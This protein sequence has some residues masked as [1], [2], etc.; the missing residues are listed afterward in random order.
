MKLQSIRDDDPRMAWVAG[1]KVRQAAYRDKREIYAFRLHRALFRADLASSQA[2]GN[3]R[4]WL[5]LLIVCAG[6]PRPEGMQTLQKPNFEFGAI[7]SHCGTVKDFLF[8][9]ESWIE[10]L[11]SK[12]QT[13][14]RML[15]PS[16]TALR[17]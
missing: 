1:R 17:S 14:E 13:A 5:D 3:R 12:L 16:L 11:L 10:T 2:K 8:M 9:P 15:Q 7:L 4:A 6:S